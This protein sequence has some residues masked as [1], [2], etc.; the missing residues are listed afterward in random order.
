MALESVPVLPG[1]HVCAIGV[2][3]GVHRG[4]QALLARARTI[5]DEQGVPLVA[6]TFDPHP[7][8]V[9]RPSAAPLLLTTVD[10]RIG[11]LRDAGA[12]EV[13]VL[14]FDAA[15]AALSPQDFVERV[16]VERLHASA[17]VVGENFTFG[18]GAK[19][20]AAT[21]AELGPTHGFTAEAVGL[22]RTNLGGTGADGTADAEAASERISSSAIRALV[23]AGDVEQA[24]RLLGREFFAD[25]VVV[26]GDHRG[27][28]LGIPTANIHA[29]PG[30]V[31]PADGVYA[32]WLIL[33]ADGAAGTA[34][35]ALPAAISVGVN[36]QF[37]GTERRIESHVLGR[38]DLDLYGAPVRVRLTALVRGQEVFDTLDAFLARID[39]DLTACRRILGVG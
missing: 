33:R 7:L 18:K 4:H 19:G 8:A 3:D 6:V 32:G 26:H 21:L 12:D 13:V 29:T 11:L 24:A 10:A 5:A 23:L 2:F 37:D 22:Q 17:V 15:M 35:T 1:P 31:V 14:P 9:V 36:P 27:R 16:L 34:G 20:T 30:L 39:A 38:D 25:G 28:E